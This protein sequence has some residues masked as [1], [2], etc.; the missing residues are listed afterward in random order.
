M[1][2]ET[3][4]PFSLFGLTQLIDDITR[5]NS[6]VEYAICLEDRRKGEKVGRGRGNI[7][8][9]LATTATATASSQSSTCAHDCY[10]VEDHENTMVFFFS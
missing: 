6:Q 4:V 9:C 8:G 2:Y 1:N 10:V 7:D 5:E 3:D